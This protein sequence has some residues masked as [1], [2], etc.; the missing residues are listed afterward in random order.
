VN[1]RD[2]QQLAIRQFSWARQF[3]LPLFAKL[4]GQTGINLE[5]VVYYKAPSHHYMVMTPTKRS[6]L[7]AGVLKSERNASG[8]LHGSN[9]DIQR[10][11]TM[12]QGIAAFFGLPTELSESQGAMIF[13]FS[14]IQRQEKAAVVS[15]D[16]LVC[17]VGDALL[18]PFWPE[19]LGI[20]R[21]F[22][23]VLDA[24]SAIVVAASGQRE[25]AMKQV[26]STYHVLK[27][28][29]AQ[30]ASQFL[31]KDHRNYRLDPKSR[32]SPAHL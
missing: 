18:E 31:Q 5:N 7:E 21:G 3:N 30:T 10:L 1:N 23:S 24:V 29:A 11:S 6:L 25:K 28:V 8:L 14:G 32:Y 26:Q 9:V 17:P 27:S 19:G 12:V 13:D 2:S 22:M 15:G 16:V 4:K 20:M